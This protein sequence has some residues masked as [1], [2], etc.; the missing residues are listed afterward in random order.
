MDTAYYLAQRR[1][2]ALPQAAI[3]TRRA[4]DDQMREPSNK[5]SLVPAIGNPTDPKWVGWGKYTQNRGIKERNLLPAM[6]QSLG[7]LVK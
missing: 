4:I 7:T 3:N 6:K 1:L 2:L 5:A